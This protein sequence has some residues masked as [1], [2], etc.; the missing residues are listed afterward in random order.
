MSEITGLYIVRENFE[1]G[2]MDDNYITRKSH[3]VSNRKFKVVG[4]PLSKSIPAH[5]G[6][7]IKITGYGIDTFGDVYYGY[8][9]HDNVKKHIYM[10]KT[11]FKKL[12]YIETPEYKQFVYYIELVNKVL[13]YKETPLYQQISR[14]TRTKCGRKRRIRRKT[15]KRRKSSIL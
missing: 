9:V 11:Q 1:A 13:D 14:T 15:H 5:K 8:L 6:D 12:D 3:S 7:I 4:V 10:N 2:V